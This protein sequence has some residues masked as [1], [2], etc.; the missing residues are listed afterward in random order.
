MLKK[1]M[2]LTLILAS[3]VACSADETSVD[4]VEWESYIN[5]RFGFS[6]E[7]PSNWPIGEESD[8][9]D[10]INLYVGNPDVRVLVYASYYIEEISDL[11]E[12]VEYDGFERQRVTLDNG[13]SADL[14]LGKIEGKVFYKL[15]FI[16]NDVVYN[17]NAEVS[18]SFFEENE[19]VL[20][21]VVKS[22]DVPLNS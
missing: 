20:L 7:Y 15:V 21:K 17:V 1:F 19:G 18:E 8:N 2:F 14:I 16:D 5:S 4:S 6:V 12:S 3:L 11:Y 13:K 10:G 9:G 22:L